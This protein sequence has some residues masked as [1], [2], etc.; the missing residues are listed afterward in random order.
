MQVFADGLDRGFVVRAGVESEIRLPWLP[1]GVVHMIEVSLVGSSH[2]VIV[3]PERGINV[4]EMRA[5]H[6]V[7]GHYVVVSANRRSSEDREK[8]AIREVYIP[9]T[10]SNET[11]HLDVNRG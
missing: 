10:V 9:L 8:D 7:L 2:I 6:D 11:A 4:V 3:L 5:L 1:H